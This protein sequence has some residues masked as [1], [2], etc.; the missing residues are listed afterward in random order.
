MN[1]INSRRIISLD[2]FICSLGIRFIG[3]YVAKMLADYY[4]SFE[5]WYN[6]MIKLQSY[7]SFSEL[8]DIKGVG[9]K[10]AESIRSFFSNQQNVNMLNNL[11]SHLKI[12][13]IDN[14]RN[15]SSLSGKVIVFTGTL[16]MSRKDAQEKAEN[17]GAKVSSEVSRSTSLLV[18]GDNPGSKYNKALKLGIKIL[19]A[20]E[21]F[22]MLS[23]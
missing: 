17:L 22:A 7:D 10:I 5:N 4:V 8:N 20:K 6:S 21:W 18:V 23:E 9:E 3:Q 15:N 12:L 16:S 11:V 13:P 1:S 19:S 14:N 2:K